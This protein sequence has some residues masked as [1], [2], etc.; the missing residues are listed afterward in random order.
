M[1]QL[2]DELSILWVYTLTMILFCPRQNLPKFFKNRTIFSAVLLFVCISASILS[3][4][5]PYVN[6]FALMTLIIPTVYLLCC[7]LE[8]IRYKESEVF[9]L[10]VRSL[11]LMVSQH[12]RFFPLFLI[13]CNSRFIGLRRDCLVQWP[14]IL[15]LLHIHANHFLTC[16]LACL[17]FPIIIHDVCALCILFRSTRKAKG[18]LQ[19]VLLATKHANQCIRNPLC[20]I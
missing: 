2:L 15:W 6:A 4:W 8:R 5:R 1:G 10:G 9:S 7:E 3:V 12:W 20:R 19:A 13:K 17:D 16:S 14:G 18:P 11:L